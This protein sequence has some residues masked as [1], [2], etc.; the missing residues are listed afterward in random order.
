[1]QSRRGSIVPFKLVIISTHV[2]PL[3]IE[4]MY[5]GI[6]MESYKRLTGNSNA[7][8]DRLAACSP[9]MLRAAPSDHAAG[10][11]ICAVP[12]ECCCQSLTCLKQD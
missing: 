2:V 11:Y 9:L 3:L 1:M 12:S 4:A 10:C 6:G 7:K 5:G 8:K